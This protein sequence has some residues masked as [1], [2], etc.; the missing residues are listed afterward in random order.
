M[1]PS[2]HV[3]FPLLEDPTVSFVAWTT[4]PWTLP[5]NMALVVNP[6]FVYIKFKDNKTEQIYIVA[7]CRIKEI[8]S[9]EKKPETCYTVI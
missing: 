1:D 9:K 3:T 7:E 4:T 6:T 2:I 5:S 8:Y